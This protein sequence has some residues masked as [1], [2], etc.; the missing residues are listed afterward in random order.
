MSDHQGD[1]G[2]AGPSGQ[3]SGGRQRPPR[4]DVVIGVV[5]AVALVVALFIPQPQ[6]RRL[7]VGVLL[8]V[9][10]GCIAVLVV[11]YRE[12]RKAAAAERDAD[13]GAPDDGSDPPEPGDPWRA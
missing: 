7:I 3:S 13:A 1:E 8:A 10:V 6:E 2:P 9:A 11:S 12:R 5:G 4:S